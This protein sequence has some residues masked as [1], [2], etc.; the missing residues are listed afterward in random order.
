MQGAP[1]MQW[2]TISCLAAAALA[3]GAPAA[4]Q[5]QAEPSAASRVA[6]TIA[7]TR[8]MITADAV[9]NEGFVTIGGIEQWIQV[10]GRHKDNPIL[11]FLHGGPGFTVSPVSYWYMRDW[12][13][14]FTLVQW[15]QRG[16]GKTFAANDPAAVKASLDLDRMVTDTEELIGYLRQ[17]YGQDRIVLM[18]HSFGTLLGSRVAQERPEWLHAYVG[19]G[20]FVD[21][22]RCEALGYAATLA[23]AR[24][25]GNQEAVAQLTAIAP[26]P[27]SENPERNLANLGIERRWLAEYGGY[28]WPRG[29]GHNGAI[30]ALNP[31]ETPQSLRA[32]DE[33]QRV[34]DEALWGELGAVDLSHETQFE[35]PVVILQGRHDLGTSSQVA[36]EWFDSLEAPAKTLVWFEDSAHMVYE[37]EPGKLLVTLVNEVLPLTRPQTAP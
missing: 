17:A 7:A 24:A 6:A 8:T 30:A 5:E 18:G 12:E 34:S 3:M 22:Q 1:I 15:D 29:T 14:Y 37:E 33:G 32:R 27:D 31:A 25:A 23:A 28:Y 11:L 13:E 19:M 9:Y 26:F 16:A 10:R 21:F 4:A 35:T 20:Q 36:S 2:T